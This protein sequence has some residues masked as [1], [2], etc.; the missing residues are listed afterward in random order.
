MGGYPRIYDRSLEPTQWLGDYIATYVQGD[1]RQVL[2][3]TDLDA[4]TPF[5][6]LAAARTGQELKLAGLGADAGVTHNTAR[7]WV[8]VLEA[9]FIVFWTP[10]WHRNLRKR[11]IRTAKLHF[12]DSGLACW[13]PEPARLPGPILLRGPGSLKF[14]R[15]GQALED[16]LDVIAWWKTPGH[17]ANLRDNLVAVRYQEGLPCFNRT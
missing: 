6:R 12:V 14:A 8:S 9:S 16:V 17:R 13:Q 5:L 15:L 2:N 10:A 3:V 11:A 4:F 1:V 7:A